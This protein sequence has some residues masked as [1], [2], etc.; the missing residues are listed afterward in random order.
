MTSGQD[1]SYNLWGPVKNGYLGPNSKTIKNFKMVRAGLSLGPFWAQSPVWL[2]K[3]HTHDTGLASG[4]SEHGFRVKEVTTVPHLTPLPEK[5]KENTSQNW[6][7]SL[8]P[9]LSGKRYGPDGVDRCSRNERLSRECHIRLLE[10]TKYKLVPV[11][12]C[13]RLFR[14]R[15][16]SLKDK[17]SCWDC[18]SS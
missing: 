4:G 8:P 5:L 6:R 15:G 16:K 7:F 9:F 14:G 10:K 1:W 17:V 18:S 13:D 12:D 3:S 2:P 11:D